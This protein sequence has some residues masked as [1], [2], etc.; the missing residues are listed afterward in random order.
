MKRA[1]ILEDQPFLL[2]WGPLGWRVVRNKAASPR[3]MDLLPDALGW[4]MITITR[5][6]K[7]DLRFVEG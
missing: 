1:Q 3:R 5:P 7:K 2:F 6:P 4:K